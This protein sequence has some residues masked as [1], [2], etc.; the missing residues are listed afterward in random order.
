LRWDEPLG[1]RDSLLLL[2]EGA[3]EHCS[4]DP[5]LAHLTSGLREATEE[6]KGRDAGCHDDREAG[7]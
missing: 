3:L 2:F 4:R 5:R 1:P 6:I 7:P